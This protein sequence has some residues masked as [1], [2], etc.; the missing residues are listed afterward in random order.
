M[1]EKPTVDDLRAAA[2]EL[3]MH[4]SEAYLAAVAE[5]VTPLANAY[6]ALDAEPDELPAVKYRRGQ[7]NRPAAAENPHGAWYVKTSIKG[8]A[9][10]KLAGR[11]IALKDNICLAGVPMMIGAQVLEGYVPDVDATVVERVL[12]AGG[13]IAGKAVCEYFCVSGGSHTSSTGP[14]HNP[15]RRG[16]TT[17]G[18]SSGCAA[19]VASGDVDMAI[20]GDQAGSIR[21]PASHCGI[22]GL[23][24]TFGLVPYT[25]IGLLEVTIDTC[26]PMT[27]G[28]RDNALLLEVIAGPDGLDPRQRGFAAARY[29]EAL[30][31]GVRGM[32]IAV[33][34]EGFGHPNSEPDVDAHV[35]AAADRFARLGAVVEE[36]SA[37]VHA[38]GFPVWAAIRGD[39]ACVMLLEMNGAGI[40]CEGLY[41]TSLLDH[42]MGWRK[43][44]D[45]FADTL[46]IASIFSRYTLDRHGGHFYAKAQNLRRRVRAGYDAV[47]AAHDL[48]LLPTVPMKATPIPAKDAS[49][50]EITRRSWEPT[51]NT[52]PFNVTGH[53]AISIPCG[54]EDGRPVGL[55][56]VGRHYAEETIYRAALAFE[57]SGDW[58]TF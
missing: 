33:L 51:R 15:R 21:I 26:G 44:A 36:V 22:V 52:C 45:E 25:G 40:G 56:L 53:P 16:Y 10:G 37:P 39:A 8:S 3:G 13:E 1:F 42:A 43:R 46:K 58:T 49:P 9:G 48:L 30:A 35:R 6:A 5:I 27:A 14:V 12:D 28:V 50:Q 23:K 2:H 29:T 4:P 41:V 17:G 57:Q 54:L 31:G 11:R 20:G 47:L 55:M 24:P 38:L 7:F 18:S 19:L 34:K 32:R